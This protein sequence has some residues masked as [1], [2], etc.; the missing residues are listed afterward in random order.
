[1]VHEV[2]AVQIVID[3]AP[4]CI[5]ALG[6]FASSRVEKICMICEDGGPLVVGRE[7]EEM[8]RV[9]QEALTKGA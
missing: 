1:M 8:G 4:P 5:G 7:L 6:H 2:F 3:A 9:P